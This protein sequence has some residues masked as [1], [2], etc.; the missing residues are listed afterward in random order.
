[1]FADHHNGGISYNPHQPLDDDGSLTK[2]KKIYN[3]KLIIISNLL[4]LS[5][6]TKI[7]KPLKILSEKLNN[8]EN[9]KVSTSKG[10]K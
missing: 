1:M 6:L 4:H 5:K 9:V 2:S 3:M 8:S 10:W 7:I